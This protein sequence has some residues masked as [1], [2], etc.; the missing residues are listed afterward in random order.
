M[1]AYVPRF[2]SNDDFENDLLLALTGR[3]AAV[4]CQQWEAESFKHYNR[5]EE[6]TLRRP[7]QR[8]EEPAG[9]QKTSNRIPWTWK[10]A[11]DCS[12]TSR[13]GLC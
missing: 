7:E 9:N 1:C 12:S 8:D 11:L 4:L 13:A 3:R 5:V 10:G 2:A 6:T